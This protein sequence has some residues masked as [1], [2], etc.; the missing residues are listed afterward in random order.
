[1]AYETL[2]R[3]SS[4]TLQK[5]KATLQGKRKKFPRPTNSNPLDK[6]KPSVFLSF[7]LQCKKTCGS[8][9]FYIVCGI[10]VKCWSALQLN[11]I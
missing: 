9:T 7:A 2:S 11:W 5:R 8:V 6:K 1:M 3:D 4:V 10:Y